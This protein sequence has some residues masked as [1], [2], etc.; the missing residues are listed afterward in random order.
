MALKLFLQKL[1]TLTSAKLK[2]CTRTDVSLRRN[3]KKLRAITMCSAFTPDFGYDNSNIILFG[4]LYC[5]NTKC[6]GTFSMHKKTF[7]LSAESI[8]N[9]RN[10]RVCVRCAIFLLKIK[11]I[12]VSCPLVKDFT[13]LKRLQNQFKMLLE[14]CIVVARIVPTE[15]NAN[16]LRR[17][18]NNSETHLWLWK[19]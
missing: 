9:A 15:R 11:Q 6:S 2:I 3:V 1:S 7:H 4:D 18:C 14:I 12:P 13:I 17:L 19:V 5:P 16:R 8:I 10:A